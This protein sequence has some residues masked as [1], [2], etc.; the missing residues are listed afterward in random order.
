MNN[1]TDIEEKI[2]LSKATGIVLSIVLKKEP[3]PIVTAVK[4]YLQ[5]AEIK[6]VELMPETLYGQEIKRSKLLLNEI[7]KITVLN[8]YF[9]DPTYVRLRLSKKKFLKTE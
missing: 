5:S 4:N 7:V 8:V 1:A 6:A 3:A 2:K 9:N